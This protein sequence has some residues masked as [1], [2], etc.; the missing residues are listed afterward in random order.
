MSADSLDHPGE[1]MRILLVEDEPFYARQ[2]VRLL[3]RNLQAPFEALSAGSLGEALDLLRRENISVAICDLNLG[4]SAGANTAIALLNAEPTLP[5]IVLTGAEEEG[6]A[7]SVMR[8]GAQDFLRKDKDD[9]ARLAKSIEFAIERK[10]HELALAMTALRLSYVDDL[11]GLPTR[12]LLN[13]HWPQLQARCVRSN[14]GLAV[15]VIDLDGFKKINNEAGHLV[16]DEVLREVGSRLQS[17][18][19]KSDQVYRFGGDEFIILL[20]GP[21]SDAGVN[22]SI[23]SLQQVMKN[24]VETSHGDIDVSMS[25]G[26]VLVPADK[27]EESTLIALFDEADRAMYAAKER[28]ASAALKAKITPAT[29]EPLA[30]VL[31]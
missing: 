21:G 3:N 14:Q 5:V 7:M 19:R 26:S 31:S 9:E 27:V 4:D 17:V 20:E 15:L 13:E 11:T 29:S 18:V 22:R 25:I 1:P 28:N 6:L 23:T 30:T 24:P 12:G 16:G 8:A 10:K 2:L